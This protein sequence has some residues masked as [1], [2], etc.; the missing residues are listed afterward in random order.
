MVGLNTHLALVPELLLRHPQIRIPPETW[1]RES[2]SKHLMAVASP[3]LD[4]HVS[5]L[6]KGLH[7]YLQKAKRLVSLTG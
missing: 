1:I 5:H 2:V 4:L 7:Q 6:R 3:R